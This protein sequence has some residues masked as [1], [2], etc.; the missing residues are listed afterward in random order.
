MLHTTT[1]KIAISILDVSLYRGETSQN[2][3]LNLECRLFEFYSG[4]KKLNR[5]E[6]VELQF[7]LIQSVQEM[8]YVDPFQSGF[9]PGYGTETE[10]IWWMTYT[11]N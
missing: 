3:E 1:T 5:G 4:K 7:R 6:T 2:S 10:S 8:K 9:K 11:R